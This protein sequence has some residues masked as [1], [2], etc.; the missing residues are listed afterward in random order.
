MSDSNTPRPARIIPIVPHGRA[1]TVSGELE[2]RQALPLALYVHIPW[3]VQKCPYCDFNSH[4]A[5]G[6][7]PEAEYVA[8]LIA[9]LESALPL[10]WG[11]RV[12]SVSQST[13]AAP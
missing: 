4:E 13:T 8:A 2:F 10:V 3:C 6:G 7:I 11:R 5:R 12:V 9:D 1:A